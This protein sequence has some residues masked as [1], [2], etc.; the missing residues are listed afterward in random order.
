MLDVGSDL[1]VSRILHTPINFID[2]RET[3]PSAAAGCS[4]LNLVLFI[5]ICLLQ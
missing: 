3:L 4:V 1:F 2:S 5:L